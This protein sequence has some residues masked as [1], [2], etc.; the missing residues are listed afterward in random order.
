MDQNQ[1]VPP[2][3]QQTVPETPNT[4]K[5]TGMVVPIVV[6]LFLGAI[7]IT[8]AIYFLLPQKKQSNVTQ[9]VPNTNNQEPWTTYTDNQLG[10]FFDYPQTW[11]LENDKTNPKKFILSTDGSEPGEIQGEFMTREQFSKEKIN[12]CDPEKKEEVVTEERHCLI[13]E[14]TA[15]SSAYVYPTIDANNK[16]T[17]ATAYITRP[18]GAGFALKITKS[19]SDSYDVFLNIIDTLQFPNEKRSVPLLIC[20]DSWSADRK[21]VTY[22]GITYLASDIQST[23]K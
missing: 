13:Y 5:K 6:L 14:K 8:A 1:T 16:I 2:A 17:S 18:N 15:G 3:T 12:T 21:T 23:C 10:Y 22:H 7:I 11:T 20:P 4:P 19:N 9:T